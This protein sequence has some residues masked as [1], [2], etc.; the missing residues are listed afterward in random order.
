MNGDNL[1]YGHD[2][3]VTK[4]HLSCSGSEIDLIGQIYPASSKNHKFVV[5]A[6]DYFT[7]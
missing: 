6:T 3:F 7:K 4:G 2:V 5:V 1:M